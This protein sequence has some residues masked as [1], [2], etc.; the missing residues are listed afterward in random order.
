MWDRGRSWP[1]T[2][3]AIFVREYWTLQGRRTEV[4]V[5]ILLLTLNEEA[6]LPAC[7]EALAWCD[8]IVVV[9]SF[10]TDRTVEIASEAGARVIRRRFDNFAGQRNHA[11]ENVPF[12]H[13]WIFHLDA[14]EIFTTGLLLEIREVIAVTSL[15]AFRVPSKMMFFGK[16]LRY[17]GM[18][19]TYQV[20]LTRAP[21]FRFMQVGHG[22]REDLSPEK[23]GTLRNPYLHY[24]FSKGIGEWFDKH[25][26][27]ARLEAVET[28]LH[29]SE[30]EVGW[31]ELFSTDATSRRRTLKKLSFRLPL[32][33]LF[34]FLYMYILRL[35]VLDGRQGLTYCALLSIFEY[36]IVLNIREI[37]SQEHQLRNNLPL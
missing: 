9:D 32:R 12:R 25:N 15:E 35:G 19:P 13:E 33:P 8:D 37:Q 27:Y 2:R 24:S 7:F 21:D 10:S 11:L 3:H 4:P 31:G 28:I 34:R 18:Y 20:R 29:L 17:S 5:S 36:M 16:W 14:D 26:R 23:I 6:N 30:G 22:Q 1:A